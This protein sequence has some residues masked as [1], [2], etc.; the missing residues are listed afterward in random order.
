[1]DEREAVENLRR[2]NIGGL[3][4]L[5]RRYHLRAGRTAYLIVRDHALAEDV[6]QNAFVRA[7]ERIGQYDPERPFAPWFMRIVVNGAV[8]AARARERM[9]SYDDGEVGALM[10]RFADPTPGPQELAERAEQRQ[11]VWEALEKLPPRQRAVVVQ[12]Y[13]LGMSETEMSETSGRPPGTIKSRLYAARRRL[14]GLLRAQVRENETPEPR[15]R[16]VPA[17]VP[18]YIPKEERS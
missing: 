17:S 12:R 7:Y 2:G 15:K 5:V 16:A 6:A 10:A 4:G 11:G 18:P 14:K 8:E 13:Y 3:E 9:S 1:M